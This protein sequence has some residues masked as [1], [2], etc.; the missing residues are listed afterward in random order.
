MVVANKRIAI[1]IV[2][3][4]QLQSKSQ[5][6]RNLPKMILRQAR[7]ELVRMTNSLKTFDLE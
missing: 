3:D 1:L 2:E 5:R 7:T 6:L 4:T